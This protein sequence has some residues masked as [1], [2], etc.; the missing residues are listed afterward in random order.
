MVLARNQITDAGRSGGN[1]S[2]TGAVRSGR[3]G[4]S[5]V[6]FEA[7]TPVSKRK[8][9]YYALPLLWRDRVVGWGDLSIRNGA[10]HAAFGYAA[11]K[12]PRDRGFKRELDAEVERV[13]WFLS[14]ETT[15]VTKKDTKVAK[16]RFRNA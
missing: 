3:V 4:P 5:P 6:R 9:A 13:R 2:I 11:G 16:E 1:R 10:L 15:K 8:L 7:Y 12:P 14:P